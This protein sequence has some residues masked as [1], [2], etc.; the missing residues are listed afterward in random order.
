M[1]L[2]SLRSSFGRSAE[3]ILCVHSIAEVLVLVLLCF[4][5]FYIVYIMTVSN[6]FWGLWQ[7]MLK[8]RKNVVRIERI[9]IFPSGLK[10]EDL[11]LGAF[12]VRVGHGTVILLELHVECARLRP[13]NIL[14]VVEYF[15]RDLFLYFYFRGSP[16]YITCLHV[17]AR[18]PLGAQS[19]GCL[20]PYEIF[21][22]R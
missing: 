2:F 15:A 16:E 8:M 6:K 3:Y 4:A 21:L 13:L 14:V 12:D 7:S 10:L 18:D 19:I 5:T 22:F 11:R 17:G 1:R 9:G 20:D